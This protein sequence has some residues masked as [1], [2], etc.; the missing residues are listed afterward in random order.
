[1]EEVRLRALSCWFES[2]FFNR[3]AARKERTALGC[4]GSPAVGPFS[5]NDG[6]STGQA[7]PDRQMWV[8]INSGQ[9]NFLPSLFSAFGQTQLGQI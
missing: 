4:S 1:M 2:T 7:F 9:S 6:P 5:Q 3:S 8:L